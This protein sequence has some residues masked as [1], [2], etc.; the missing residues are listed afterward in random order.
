ML[1][2]DS[3]LREALEAA[4]Q[5]SGDEW[6]LFEKIANNIV[7]SSESWDQA[8]EKLEE[9]YEELT[10][11]DTYDS[12]WNQLSDLCAIAGMDRKWEEARVFW[13]QNFI[14]REYDDCT[15]DAKRQALILEHEMTEEDIAIMMAA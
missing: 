1:S 7:A 15:T 14:R 2:Q 9:Y 10:V 12:I 4:L 13:I 8:Y 11:E 5:A 6:L 3:E